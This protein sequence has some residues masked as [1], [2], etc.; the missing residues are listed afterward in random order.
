[1]GDCIDTSYGFLCTDCLLIPLWDYEYLIGVI[2]F[3]NY[4]VTYYFCIACGR[5]CYDLVPE[6]I[7]IFLIPFLILWWGY[8]YYITLWLCI[9]L[10]DILI[11]LELD[12]LFYMILVM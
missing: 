3:P 5:V 4:L 11:M 12:P 7:H 8:Y 6:V 9:F 10:L 1:M 2:G